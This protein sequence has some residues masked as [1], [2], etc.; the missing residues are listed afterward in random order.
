V[1]I[2]I[3]QDEISTVQHEIPALIKGISV[4]YKQDAQN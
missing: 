4:L 1:E 3:F 2:S